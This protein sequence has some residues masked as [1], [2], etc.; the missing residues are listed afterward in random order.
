MEE[1]AVPMEAPGPG[2]GQAELR[3]RGGVQAHPGLPLG[4][5]DPAEHLPPHLPVSYTHLTLPT[6]CSV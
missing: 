2:E 6:I 3:P 1:A 4:E 5:E